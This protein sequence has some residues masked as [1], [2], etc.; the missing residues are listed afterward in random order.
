MVRE[1]AGIGVKSWTYP[2]T[3]VVLN[4]SHTRPHGNV[5]TEFHTPTGPFTQVPLPEIAP[6]SSG[7][8]RRSRRK[9]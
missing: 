9:N 6:A 7:S 1:A 4:L 5:S 8:S 2:Q 3:A